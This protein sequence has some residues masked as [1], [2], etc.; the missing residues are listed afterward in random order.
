M[1]CDMR[2]LFTTTEKV[3]LYT[4]YEYMN[5]HIY[6]CAKYEAQFIFFCIFFFQAEY[7]LLPDEKLGEKGKEIV[8]KYLI[9]GVRNT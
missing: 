2:F 8:M 5:I 3:Y 9:P 4:I 7:E 6:A 1:F